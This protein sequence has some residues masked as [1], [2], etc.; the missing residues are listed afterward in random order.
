MKKNGSKL[1]FTFVLLLSIF[2]S[3]TNKKTFLQRHNQTVQAVLIHLSLLLI[4]NILGPTIRITE[5]QNRKI[6][7][8]GAH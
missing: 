1:L 2:L 5:F 4:H 7:K 3:L 8:K 6:L